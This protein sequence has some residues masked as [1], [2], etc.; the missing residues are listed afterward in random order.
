MRW[1]LSS[2]RK[3]LMPPRQ[4]QQNSGAESETETQSLE[5][6]GCQVLKGWLPE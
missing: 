5:W 1:G 2:Q 3:A 4:L 6:S